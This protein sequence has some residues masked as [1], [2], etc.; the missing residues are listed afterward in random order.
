ML[1]KLFAFVLPILAFAGHPMPR[2]I[3]QP[4]PFPAALGDPILWKMHSNLSLCAMR[5]DKESYVGACKK[6]TT[7]IHS[8]GFSPEE[9]DW[10]CQ[11][12][13]VEWYEVEV[14]GDT[15]RAALRVPEG[16]KV[17]DAWIDEVT[18]KATA[19]LKDPA[20]GDLEALTNEI[21]AHIS[22]LNLKDTEKM[23][24]IN[25]IAKAMQEK[26]PGFDWSGGADK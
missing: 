5:K 10:L 17:S 11:Q 9:E 26:N 19:F 14:F 15:L 20:S 24:V 1:I 13:A 7:F 8:L 12:V 23:D 22:S 21:D 2:I 18:T 6:Y 16:P 3:P 25:R 4:S